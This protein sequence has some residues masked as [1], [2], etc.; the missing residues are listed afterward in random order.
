MGKKV[1]GKGTMGREWKEKGKRRRE[2][3]EGKGKRE[4]TRE[5]KEIKSKKGRIGKEIK[6]V[7]PLNTP[8]FL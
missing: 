4:G 7:A 6:L 8:V 2:G 3:S 5:V 1:R